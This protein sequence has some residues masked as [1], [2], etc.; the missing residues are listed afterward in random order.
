VKPRVSLQLRRALAATLVLTL[1]S[2]LANLPP[3]A[4]PAAAPIFDPTRF[5]DGHTRGEGTLDARI[6]ADRTLR[7]EGIGSTEADGR[8]RLE[9]T[10]T[11]S[12]SSVEN[13]VWFMQRVDSTHFTATLSDAKGEVQ[14]EVKGTRFHLRY[15]IRRPAVY[16]EQWMTLSADGQTAENHA[17]VTVLGLPWARLSEKISRVDSLRP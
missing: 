9:Q 7:V 12:D 1:G 14:A 17:E 15:L 2:C 5:F 4:A 11:F 16:M 6:G 13:R 8:F 3:R 10:I